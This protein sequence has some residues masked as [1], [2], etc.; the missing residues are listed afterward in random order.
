MQLFVL[1]HGKAA[2]PDSLKYPDDDRPL[3]DEGRD[4]IAQVAEEFSK[5]KVVFEHIFASP[6]LRTTETAEIVAE[7]LGLKVEAEPLLALDGS[8]RTLL[9]K[10]KNIKAK[11]VLLVGHEPGLI[12]L[13]VTVSGKRNWI[14]KPG[15]WEK[16]EL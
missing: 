16:V 2:K 10:L 5:S 13:L 11:S 1:R 8:V 12:D 7:K 3:V 14:L 9:N 4:R 15:H 6:Y